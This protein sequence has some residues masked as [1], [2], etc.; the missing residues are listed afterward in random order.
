MRARIVGNKEFAI[1]I[2]NR[3]GQ[4]FIDR[5]GRLSRSASVPC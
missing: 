2:V 3:E 1:D 5:C 4:V